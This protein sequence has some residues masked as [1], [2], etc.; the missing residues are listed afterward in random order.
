VRN[1]SSAWRSRSR[2]SASTVAIAMP[3]GAAVYGGLSFKGALAPI[4][5]P[6]QTADLQ[7]QRCDPDSLPLS[8][9]N[10]TFSVKR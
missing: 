4:Y 5:R 3:S 2:T 8:D 7:A 9:L 6:M 1:R 10:E